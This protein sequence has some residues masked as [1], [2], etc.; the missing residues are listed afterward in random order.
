LVLTGCESGSLPANSEGQPRG[1][2]E[3]EALAGKL[4]GITPTLPGVKLFSEAE[5]KGGTMLTAEAGG[6]VIKFVIT[7]DVTGS[8]SGSAGEGPATGKLLASVNLTFAQSRGT[9]KYKGFSE[10][11]EAGLPGNLEWDVNGSGFEPIG[12]SLK[13]TM[14]TV[15]STRGLGITK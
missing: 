8:L 12:W 14:K 3:T 13:Q 11:P 5:G 1:T 15:P 9:Q 6:G 10:G 7:C 2:I 4:E